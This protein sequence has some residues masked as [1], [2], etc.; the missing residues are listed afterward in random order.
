MK[1]QHSVFVRMWQI[2]NDAVDTGYISNE[3]SRGQK[4]QRMCFLLENRGIQ[5]DVL[6]LQEIL[7][8]SEKD[9]HFFQE[10][11]VYMVVDEDYLSENETH[12]LQIFHTYPGHVPVQ[13]TVQCEFCWFVDETGKECVELTISDFVFFSWMPEIVELL[14]EHSGENISYEEMIGLLHNLG[15]RSVRGVGLRIEEL[16]GEDDE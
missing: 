9:A 14:E 15:Y 7:N 6:A 16:H 3:L 5:P 11:K 12:W 4:N 10:Q 13:E 8:T 2:Y 1:K